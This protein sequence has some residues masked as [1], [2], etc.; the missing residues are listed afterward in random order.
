MA[1]IARLILNTGLGHCR[2][3]MTNSEQAAWKVKFPLI[4]FLNFLIRNQQA[5]E[6]RVGIGRLM[7]VFRRKITSGSSLFNHNPALSGLT[8]TNSLTEEFTE[9]LVSIIP[10]STFLTLLLTFSLAV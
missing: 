3:A 8:L 6:A 9:A 2:R 1:L 5:L 4:A 10:P 7:P